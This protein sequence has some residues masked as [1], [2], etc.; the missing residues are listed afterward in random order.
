MQM[1]TSKN[2]T[3]IPAKLVLVKAGSENPDAVPEKTG[4][5][6]GF[7]RIEYGAGLLSPE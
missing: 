5:D 2:T 4:E 6:T 3:F 1:N 7:S